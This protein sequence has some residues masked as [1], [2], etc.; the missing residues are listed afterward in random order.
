MPKQASRG[1][2][3]DRT[4]RI[5]RIFQG[6]AASLL[7][8]QLDALAGDLAGKEQELAALAE[9]RNLAQ[10]RLNKLS[11]I[12]AVLCVSGRDQAI[13]MVDAGIGK[14]YM[15]EFHAWSRGALEGL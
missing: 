15:D 5:S 3:P 2:I 4:R 10:L 1:F 13:A 6:A 9:L 12:I 14:Q 11:Q 7:P 8:G